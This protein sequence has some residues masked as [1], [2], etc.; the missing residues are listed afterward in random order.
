MTVLRMLIAAI[1][2]GLA[3]AACNGVEDLGDSCGPPTGKVTNVLDGDTVDLESG[4]RIRYL[5]I[6]TP[7]IA[8]SAGETPDCYGDEAKVQNEV[9]V[10]GQE[11]KLEY[12]E[13]C[14]DMFDRVLAYVFLGDRM[15]NGIMLERGYAEILFIKP[16]DRYLTELE[17]LEAAAK[18]SGAGLWSACP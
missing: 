9:L 18:S 14:D 5:L 12:D 17:K 8:H 7:E 15:V 1:P 2:I 16:N 13:E 11:V 6:D 10:A 4:V 3:L